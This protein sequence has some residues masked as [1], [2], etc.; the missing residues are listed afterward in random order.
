M[1]ERRQNLDVRF[2]YRVR[3]LAPGATTQTFTL[4]QITA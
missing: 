3:L 1:T 2:P 4:G